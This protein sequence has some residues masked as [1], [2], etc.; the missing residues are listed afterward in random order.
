M[1]RTEL[2][3][4]ASCPACGHTWVVEPNDGVRGDP[5]ALQTADSE[6]VC[7]AC[8]HGRDPKRQVN[9]YSLYKGHGITQYKDGSQSPTKEEIDEGIESGR[10][11]RY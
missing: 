8:G 10:L 6:L 5:F 1:I 3:R 9:G 7:P 11:K 4:Q 2:I